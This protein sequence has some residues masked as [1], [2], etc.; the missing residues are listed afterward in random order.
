M[1]N[2]KTKSK[3]NMENTLLLETLPSGHKVLYLIKSIEAEGVIA[4]CLETGKGV[5]IHLLT[6]CEKGSTFRFVG[7]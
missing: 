5:F 6:S 3:D 4:V 1:R 2:I 7:S